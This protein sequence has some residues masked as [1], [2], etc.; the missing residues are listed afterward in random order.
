[1]NKI[2]A[3]CGFKNSGKDTVAHMLRY[4]LS[5]P[6]FMRY[7][8]LYRLLNKF[9]ISKYKIVSFAES[10]KKSLAI[11]INVPYKLFNDRQFKEEC[12]INTKTLSI[13]YN[14]YIPHVITD[15]KI[16]KLI[17][18]NHMK[19]IFD[20][21]ITIR[22]L[23][24]LYG[25]EI[26][27]KYFGDDFWIL[28]TLEDNKNLIISDLRFINEYYRVKEKEGLII[29]VNRGLTPGCHQS[30]QEVVTINRSYNI[31]YIVNNL[32]GLKELFKE[33]KKITVY[34]KNNI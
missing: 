33:V 17:K 22:Q 1:M 2:I 27:R 25:T 26:I 10:L 3:I 24:Q 9:I 18:S 19:S 20:Y 8:W 7:Y 29:Y 30:E 15:E 12:Y 13:T 4:C 11:L 14:K 28:R 21:F 16:N 5:V 31:D 32:T 34:I 23:L 6:K